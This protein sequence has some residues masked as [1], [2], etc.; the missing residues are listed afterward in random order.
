MPNET[1]KNQ[2]IRLDAEKWNKSVS[3]SCDQSGA[4][5]YCENCPRRVHDFHCDAT[6]KERVSGSLC[7]RAARKV[8][9]SKKEG[10]R[11]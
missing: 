1:L 9:L 3:A 8:K 6:Q 5:Y 2:Q 11:S 7:S 4:M 10:N